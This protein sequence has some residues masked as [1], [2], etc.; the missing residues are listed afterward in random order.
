MRALF[1]TAAAFIVMAAAPRAARACGRASGYGS[2]YASV[3]GLALAMV[4]GAADLGFTLY[5]AGS[6]AS[7]QH[8]SAA[9]GIGEL[10]V[11]GPQVAFALSVAR[12]SGSVG[13][14][15]AY[16]I[17]MSVLSGHALW[18]IASAAVGEPASTREHAPSGPDL[19]SRA[20][21][22]L[23]TTFV[24]VGQFSQPGVG[25]VGRF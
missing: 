25:L 2:G 9:Y 16:A 11:A 20:S 13:P 24:P 15:A 6:A 7:F 21:V 8:P 10:L 14:S 1:A 19:N 4:A 5:D 23:G 18:T 22:S 17:W 12:G 3:G